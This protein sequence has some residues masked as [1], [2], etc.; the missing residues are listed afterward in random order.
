MHN[1][2]SR[3]VIHLDLENATISAGVHR[4]QPVPANDT[5]SSDDTIASA[6]IEVLRV[7]DRYGNP[8]IPELEVTVERVYNAAD[9]PI[10]VRV[11][12][13]YEI[14]STDGTVYQGEDREPR[15]RIAFGK[16]LLDYQYMYRRT[17][18]A[19]KAAGYVIAFGEV[20][21]DFIFERHLDE[22]RIEIMQLHCED[23]ELI[24]YDPDDRYPAHYVQGGAT[25]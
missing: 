25:Q 20:I 9:A 7:I 11:H 10:A 17:L 16:L 8:V 6:E 24:D 14:A 21:G 13:D 22:T 12:V 19:I 4:G 1:G 3:T 5:A 15:D 2:K 18:N 23:L